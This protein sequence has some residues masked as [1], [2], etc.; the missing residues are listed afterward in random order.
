MAEITQ[1]QRD[2]VLARLTAG[3]RNKTAIGRA[4]GVSRD[5]VRRIEHI[6]Q[7]ETGGVVNVRPSMPAPVADA[8]G[9]SLPEPC[10]LDY[11]PYV[12]DVVGW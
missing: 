12:V 9:P 10:Q 5:S 6:W 7:Q 3:E 4:C 11:S 8:G 1:R 2:D